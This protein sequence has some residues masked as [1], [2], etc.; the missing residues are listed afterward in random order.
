M[1]ILTI[2]LA[3]ATVIYDYPMFPKFLSFKNQLTP[4]Q[5]KEKLRQWR[6]KY[7]HI[8]QTAIRLSLYLA[9]PIFSMPADCPLKNSAM[10]GVCNMRARGAFEAFAH[11]QTGLLYAPRTVYAPRNYFWIFDEPIADGKTCLEVMRERAQEACNIDKKCIE[12]TMSKEALS[13]VERYLTKGK[14]T[15]ERLNK[16]ELS[17]Y[18]E[19]FVWAAQKIQE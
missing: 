6:Q 10:T 5:K 9:D 3:W 16:E 8:E 2:I 18:N 1:R 15:T 12:C 11:L 7:T 4:A 13:V 19:S 17:L 14:P